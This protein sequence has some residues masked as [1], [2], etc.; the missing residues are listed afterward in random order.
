MLNLSTIKANTFYGVRFFYALFFSLFSIGATALETDPSYHFSFT[1]YNQNVSFKE[2]EQE[3]LYNKEQGNLV[4][5]E[6]KFR[7]QLETWSFSFMGDY[8]QGNLDYVGKTQLGRELSTTTEIEGNKYSLSAE[9]TVWD[10][11]NET[12][13]YCKLSAFLSI[14]YEQINRDI[15]SFENV[16]GLYEQ[17]TFSLAE[18]GISWSVK[19]ILNLDWQF[20]ISHSQAFRADLA[21]D[22]LANYS[23]TS[24][25]LNSVYTNQ[26]ELLVTYP[27]ARNTSLGFNLNYRD[28]FIEKSDDFPLYKGESVRGTF[29]QPQRE[30]QLIEI[31]VIFEFYF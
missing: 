22:F 6:Y 23:D 24:I 18:L 13:S 31:G 11:A 21:I 28:S 2:T 1:P 5:M 30:M 3:Q 27:I 26:A 20:R 16:S 14:N 7:Y 25:P 19:N 8:N 15:Q 9:R 17:Y 4:G 12:K 29:Y 10:F